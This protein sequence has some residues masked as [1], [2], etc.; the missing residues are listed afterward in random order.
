MTSSKVTYSVSNGLA[1]LVLTNVENKNAIDLQACQEFAE[2]AASVRKDETVKAV[3]LQA[4]GDIFSV[5]GDING[6]VENKDHIY[7]HVISMTNGFH[8]GISDLRNSDAPLIVAVNGMAA[9]GGFSIVCMA[10]LSIAKRSA[11]FC[12]AYTRSGLSPD[13][14]GTYFLPRTVGRARAFD[15]F[16][17][18]PTLSANEACELGII[19][20]V[21]DDVDFDAEVEK[22]AQMVVE[23]PPGAL[24]ALKKLINA[25]S[26]ANLEDQLNAEAK[27][28]ATLTDSPST[29]E[30]LLAF[31]ERSKT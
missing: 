25:S 21:V 7:D 2:A 18:N 6:F 26:T 20:R 16:A 24:A 1:R 15:I 27:S 12:A 29:M 8:A 30:R 23:S 14:G 13:G 9:G 10:D 28:I 17:T 4:Q 22:L 19:S 31:V 5:G 3:L 11:K